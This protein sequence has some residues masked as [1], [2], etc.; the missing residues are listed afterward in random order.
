MQMESFT[1]LVHLSMC[2]SIGWIV[3]PMHACSIVRTS[4]GENDR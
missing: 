1:M 4:G 3:N 2:A